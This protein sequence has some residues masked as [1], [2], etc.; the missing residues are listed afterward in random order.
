[1][2]SLRDPKAHEQRYVNA[3]RRIVEQTSRASHR[4]LRV[5]RWLQ[6]GMADEQD[7]AVVGGV[8]SA[9][10]IKLLDLREGGSLVKRETRQ[11]VVW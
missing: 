8:Y 7:G 6:G 2:A 5:G 9:Y 3:D 10:A 11:N 1:M 4:A